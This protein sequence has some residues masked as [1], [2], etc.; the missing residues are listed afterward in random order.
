M[1]SPPTRQRSAILPVPQCD[2]SNAVILCLEER[3]SHFL[4]LFSMLTAPCV[5]PFPLYTFVWGYATFADAVVAPARPHMCG[6]LLRLPV[7]T[8]HVGQST[9]RQ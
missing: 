3:M 2:A 6:V 4:S 8:V 5:L 1:G 7:P 9:R